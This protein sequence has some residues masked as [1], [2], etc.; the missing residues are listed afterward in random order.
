MTCAHCDRENPADAA[1]C[2][3]C[4]QRLQLLCRGCS[5]PNS[6]DA[7]FC[8]GCGRPL[9]EIDSPTPPVPARQPHDY[10]PKHLADKILTTKCVLEGAR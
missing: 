2:S 10:T 8:N 6:A 7:A 4:G 3:G 1:F 9:E 5:R